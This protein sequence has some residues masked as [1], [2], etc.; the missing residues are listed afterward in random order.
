MTARV[1]ALINPELLV[2]AR[3]T[4][5]LSLDQAAGKAHV[6]VE[7]LASWEGG[8]SRPSI[9]QMRK[10][11]QAYR[12]P[13][14]IFY[15]PR[16]PTQFE[17]I[18][19]FRRL[20][21][22]RRGEMSPALALAVRMARERR[23]VA[24]ELLQDLGIE[25]VTF[26]L[27]LT[28][29]EDPEAA[30]EGVMATLLPG[31]VD[32]REWKS[33]YDAFNFYRAAL[34]SAGVLVFQAED[35]DVAEMRGFAIIDPVLPVVVVN[36]KDAP[37]ARCFSLLHELAH[38][39]L[40]EGGLCDLEVGE[41][42]PPGAMEVFCN[43]VAGA[44]LVPR[45]ELLSDER[46]RRPEGGRWSEEVLRD[47]SRRFQVS[48]EVVVRRLL[49]LGKTTDAFYRERRRVYADRARLE[50]EQRALGDA[51]SGFA[52]PDKKAVSRAGPF[53]TRLVLTSYY[54]EKITSSD[55]SAFLGVRLKHVPRI[56]QAVFAREPPGA[57]RP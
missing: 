33:G 25:P 54:Q 31:G 19:D 10:L 15:L 52:T 35:V 13:L 27:S 9:P 17:A 5:R 45:A 36:I 43:R 40:R 53:F 32:R 18:R 12:R 4:A 39:A 47:L 50:S 28:P 16:P 37:V 34:E 3:Q 44:A 38:L 46:V 2:W 26:S 41:G 22:E 30:A 56:E 8:E 29:G 7:K 57:G 48:E 1:E 23:E 42:L 51:R 55:L 20:P 24:L 14:A 11:C 6:T 49:D 21:E